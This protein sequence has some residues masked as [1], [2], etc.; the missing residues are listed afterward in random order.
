MLLGLSWYGMGSKVKKCLNLP[1][2]YLLPGAYSKYFTPGVPIENYHKPLS[3]RYRGQ[4]TQLTPSQTQAIYSIASKLRITNPQWLQDMIYFETAG[5]NDPK[6]RNLGGSSARGLIQFMDS[7]ARGMGYS[8]SEDLVDRN[9]TF[10]GQLEGPVYKYL[11]PYSPYVKE[12]D[13]YMA[14]FYPAARKYS[15]DTTFAEIFRRRGAPP[16]G[17]G[18]YANFI[19]ANPGILSP[20]H[21][22]ALVKKKPLKRLLFWSG[23]IALSLGTITLAVMK[24]RKLG[25]FKLKR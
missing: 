21:Y 18:S 4:L 22:V 11:K 14:V 10:E 6:K 17:K 3:Q 20:A 7:T 9:P 23:G 12:S 5:T 1:G 24:A 25:P 8:G 16:T 2:A 13:L 19:K 15:T